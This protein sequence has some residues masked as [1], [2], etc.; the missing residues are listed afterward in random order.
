MKG[1]VIMKYLAM[2]QAR[3]NSSRLADKIFLQVNGKTMLQ[4]VIEAVGRSK[5]TDEV[6]VVTSIEKSNLRVLELCAKLGTRVFVGSEEDVLDRYYQ[7]ARLLKPEYVIRITADCPLFDGSLL[8]EAIRQMKKDS[9]YL[10]MLSET[11]AD[12]LDI[13]IITFDALR[14]AWKNAKLKSEREHVTTYIINHSEMFR[15]QDFV[16]PIGN[17]GQHRWTLDET[18]DFFLIKSVLEYFTKCGKTDYGYRDVLAYLELHPEMAEVNSMHNRN[19]G[20]LKSLQNDATI[21]GGEE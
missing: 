3:A 16:S 1:N 18:E 5:L 4:Y 2:I 21:G 8:D 20:L 19:E 13:Q 14:K 17:F 9:D 15:L 10:G 11:F 12:G 7:A 6:M